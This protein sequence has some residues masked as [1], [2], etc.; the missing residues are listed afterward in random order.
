MYISI[1]SFPKAAERWGHLQLK[2]TFKQRSPDLL[3]K[4]LRGNTTFNKVLDVEVDIL[5]TLWRWSLRSLIE[6]SLR[7]A[8]R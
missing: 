2:N 7:A 3:P 8:E 4:S 6:V 5:L 1:G